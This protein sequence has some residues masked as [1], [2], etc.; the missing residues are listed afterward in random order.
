[1]IYMCDGC[2]DVCLQPEEGGLHMIDVH[3]N[4][5]YD[6]ALSSVDRDP[7]EC[8]LTALIGNKLGPRRCLP[9]TAVLVD[10]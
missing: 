2:T 1:M 6:A 3:V 4:K 8:S 7:G 5:M 10:K 9:C